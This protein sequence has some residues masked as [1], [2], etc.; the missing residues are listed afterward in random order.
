MHICWLEY[1]RAKAKK[2]QSKAD[3]NFHKNIGTTIDYHVRSYGFGYLGFLF[4]T[5]FGIRTLFGALSPREKPTPCPAK[6]APASPESA[7]TPRNSASS[8]SAL[9]PERTGLQA[10]SEALLWQ[11]SLQW[12]RLHRNRGSLRFVRW[13]RQ[14]KLEAWGEVV[15]CQFPF[16]SCLYAGWRGRAIRRLT[17]ILCPGGAGKALS[18]LRQSEGGRVLSRTGNERVV[19]FG[20]FALPLEV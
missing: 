10:T 4:L 15:N 9:T 14:K 7:N 2:H 16:N 11:N 18:R 20:A 5:H 6:D 19:I 17:V 8:I 3:R 12:T 1:Y 13:R